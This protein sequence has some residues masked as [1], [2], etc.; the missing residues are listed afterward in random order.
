MRIQVI[1]RQKT[2]QLLPWVIAFGEDADLQHFASDTLPA[3]LHHL[4]LA[5]GIVGRLTGTRL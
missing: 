1:D 2:I 5:Q 3:V 4:Q